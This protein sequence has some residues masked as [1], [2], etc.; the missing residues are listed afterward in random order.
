MGMVIFPVCNINKLQT[1]VN[2]RPFYSSNKKCISWI[3]PKCSENMKL[4]PCL[5][6]ISS[7]ENNTTFLLYLLYSDRKCCLNHAWKH[8]FSEEKVKTP[9][10]FCRDY[11]L[12]LFYISRVI[13]VIRHLQYIF[14]FLLIFILLEIFLHLLLIIIKKSKYIVIVQIYN[15]IKK[16]ISYSIC[17]L[18]QNMCT[19]YRTYCIIKQSIQL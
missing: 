8:N 2:S 9:N 18:I 7:E 5:F 17:N 3:I 13:K 15:C 16:V 10:D 12:L 6:S 4:S 14:Y 1:Y 19:Y 11:D